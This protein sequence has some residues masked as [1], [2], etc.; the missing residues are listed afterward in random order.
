MNY[1]QQQVLLALNRQDSERGSAVAG[2]M[3][4]SVCG[5]PTWDRQ[6]WEA[7]RN[8]FGHYPFGLDGQGGYV[9]P[10]TYDDA[11]AWV[12]ELMGQREPPIRMRRPTS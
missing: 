5:P 4:Y 9:S 1:A 10:P 8:Q 12:F 11:P 3:D 7:F 6:A 2:A